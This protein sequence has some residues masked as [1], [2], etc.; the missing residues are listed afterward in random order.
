MKNEPL[1]GLERCFCHGKSPSKKKAYYFLKE[2]PSPYKGI[3]GHENGT[4]RLHN[5]YLGKDWV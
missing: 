2:S 3:L 4:L 5:A 1:L